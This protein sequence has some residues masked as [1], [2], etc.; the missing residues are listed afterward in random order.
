MDDYQLERLQINTFAVI[1]ISIIAAIQFAILYKFGLK[2]GVIFA[3]AF[4]II[5]SFGSQLFL[6]YARGMGDSKGT[7]PSREF[8][9][10]SSQ[11]LICIGLFAVYSFGMYFYITYLKTGILNKPAFFSWLILF[12][13]GPVLYYGIAAIRIYI[14]ESDHKNNYVKARI[15]ISHYNELP[16]FIEPLKIINTTNGKTSSIFISNQSLYHSESLLKQVNIRDKIRMGNPVEEPENSFIPINSD[17]LMISWYSPVEETYYT[18][19]IDFPYNEF[20]IHKYSDDIARLNLKV[21]ILPRGE[22]NIYTTK[23]RNRYTFQINSKEISEKE[24]IKFIEFFHQYNSNIKQNI[25]TDHLSIE[26]NSRRLKTRIEL[27][28]SVFPLVYNI[29]GPGEL[30]SIYFDD[31]QYWGYDCTYSKLNTLNLKPLPQNITLYFIN[32]GK[33]SY[34]RIYLFFDKEK[35]FNTIQ[36]LT[37]G[38]KD[39]PVE[40]FISIKGSKKENIEVSVQVNNKAV[41]FSDWETNIVKGD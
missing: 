6:S 24:K 13:G 1:I 4:S 16:L 37:E 20:K 34:I 39:I 22:L 21:E 27:E 17:K 30:N 26:E 7:G 28:E 11:L 5:F 14:N 23:D 31:R 40:I 32:T 12:V 35:L 41:V 19:T 15:E 33:E 29:K 9:I 10:I 36:T 8:E 2:G 3:V 18:D 38:K 25:F